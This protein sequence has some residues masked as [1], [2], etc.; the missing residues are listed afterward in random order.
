VVHTS[1]VQANVQP[2]AIRSVFSVRRVGGGIRRWGS[3]RRRLG[4]P[5]PTCWFK[6]PSFR[7][8][9]GNRTTTARLLFRTLSAVLPAAPSHQLA[10]GVHAAQPG[11]G[12][13]PTRPL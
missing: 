13:Q 8:Q 5:A 2:T 11:A 3:N 12:P 9:T 4:S 7:S 1:S 6:Q 10:Q